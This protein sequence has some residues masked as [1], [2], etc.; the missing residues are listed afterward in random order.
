[1]NELCYKELKL[2]DENFL[3][4]ASNLEAKVYFI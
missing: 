2:I 3:N 1:M 4:K